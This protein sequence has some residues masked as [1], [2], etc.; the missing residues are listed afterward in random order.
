MTIPM[1]GRM[2]RNGIAVD[3][4]YLKNLSVEI[5][6][7]REDSYNVIKSA[8]PRKALDLFINSTVRDNDDD[9]P[10]PE[11]DEAAETININ[12]PEQLADLL[13]TYMGLGKSAKLKTTKNGKRISTGKKQLEQIKS[14]HEIVGHILEYRQLTK[15]KTTYVEKMTKI[16]R[17]HPESQTWRIHCQFL[18]TRTET[19]RLASKQVNLQNIP[20][21]GKMGA[22]VRAAFIAGPGKLL[23][24]RD[25][26]QIELRVLAHEANDPVM[27]DI[28]RRDGDIHVETTLKAWKMTWDDWHKL[29]AQSVCSCGHSPESH[30]LTN[31]TKPCAQCSCN[32]YSHSGEKQQ[33]KLRTPIKCFHPDTEVLTRTGW[34]KIGLLITGEQIIQAIPGPHVSVKLEWVTPTD[35]FTAVHPSGKLHHLKNEGIDIRVTPE[36]RM[37]GWDN[38]GRPITVDPLKMNITPRY[39]ANA[40]MLDEGSID[41]IDETMLQLAVALQADGT[42]TEWKQAIWEFTKQQKIDR[43]HKL[44][45]LAKIPYNQTTSSSGINPRVTRFILKKADSVELIGLLDDKMIPWWWMELS[46]RLREVVLEEARFWDSSDHGTSYTYTSALNQNVEVLQTLAAITNHKTRAAMDKTSSDGIHKINSLTMRSNSKSRSGNVDIS[47]ADYTEEVVCLSVPSTWVLVRDGGIPIICGQSTNFGICVA[48]GQ[49][50]LT[51][52]GL[53]PIESVSIDDKVWDG[54]SFVTHSGVVFNGWKR[55]I[56]HDG[57]TA[58]PDHQVWDSGGRKCHLETAAADGIGLLVTEANS[59]PVALPDFSLGDIVAGGSPPVK[60]HLFAPVYDIVDAGPYHR[61]TVSGHLVSNCYGLSG[62]GLQQQLASDSKIYWTQEQCDEFIEL[63]FS[64]YP[65]VKSYMDKIYSMARTHG[66]VWESFGRVRLVPGVR[67]VHNHVQS[68]AL[69]EAGNFPIQSQAAAIMRLIMAHCEYDTGPVFRDAGIY[70]EPLLQIHDE[71][72]HE[73]DEDFAEIVSDYYGDLMRNEVPLRV[74]L[75]SEATIGRRWEK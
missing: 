10:R 65:N 22:K 61:F 50:V 4:P 48:G 49:Q 14:E 15:L 17:W 59:I 34:K 26:S 21:R 12:S 45:T 11:L 37:L 20:S 32:D 66:L 75:K 40:G 5:D 9:S 24:G 54:I 43:M 69:R 27:I 62:L 53:K 64:I 2:M 56:T 31:H 3:I 57:L 55:V 52:A 73:V 33:K 36:H 39:W 7:L 19:G 74:P 72:V 58:T 46:P 41:N 8:I 6:H 1:A 18:L 42:V 68:A 38:L 60:T 13:F 51:D 71:L 30:I 16:A 23:V 29:S 44:L 25:L 28:F 67:S 63:W 70:A 35:V 47:T